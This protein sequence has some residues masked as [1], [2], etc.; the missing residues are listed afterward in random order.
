MTGITAHFARWTRHAFFGLVAVCAATTSH[1]FDVTISGLADEDL[2]E[3]LEGASL[4]MEMSEREEV[5]S[6]QEIISSAQ[7]DYRRLVA[8]LYD[9]G[10]FG[11][12]VRISVDGREASELEVVTPPASVAQIEIVV[13]EGEQFRFGKVDVTPVSPSAEIPEDFRLGETASLGAIQRAARA[14]IAG[15]RQDGHAKA[16]I[17]GQ[18]VT[19]RHGANELDA[20]IRIDPGPEVTFGPLRVEGN[21][22]VRTE[23]ILEIAALPEGEVFSQDELDD[24]ADRLRRSGAFRSVALI[25]PE[26]VAADNVM[27]MTVRV[28]EDKPRRLGFGG[29]LST[30]E[31]LSLRGFWI[32]RNYLGGAERLRFDAEVSGIGGDTGGT[33]YKLGARFERPATFDE[34][35]KLFLLG[36]LESIDSKEYSS[37]QITVGGG[38][39][40]I[41]SDEITYSLGAG[42][43]YAET[44]DALGSSDYT[45]LL[46]PAGVEFDYR[47]FELDARAGYYGGVTLTPFLALSGSDNGLQTILD[48][49]RYLSFGE[50]NRTTL[51]LRG[52]LGSLIGPSLQDAPVDMLFYSGGS[53]TVRGHEYESLGVDVGGDEQVGGRSF[54]GFTTEA[55]FR[56]SGALGFVAFFDAGYIGEESYPDGSG[57]WHSGAGIGVRYAT[58]IGPIRFDFAVPTS[59]DDNG[60][61]FQIYIGIGQAF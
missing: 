23:R 28:T 11:P 33:D 57:E 49:R 2:K 26:M 15:W 8:V 42:I 25:E 10:Y 39:E 7:A 45:L 3:T 59:G 5:P 34:D 19:A 4:A 16:S 6:T 20:S 58:G 21:K 60:S 29:D 31:G 44:D 18:T 47:D 43:R 37:D 9:N 41:Y 56:T 53:D 52:Q 36:T 13:T 24:A 17:S 38:I 55:R 35:T 40:R 14:G 54:V 46:F 1:A 48:Y 32:H 50:G 30:T 51:A 61:S 27:P 12:V 22:D